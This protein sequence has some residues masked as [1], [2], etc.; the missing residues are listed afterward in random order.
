MEKI[1]K[2]DQ[3]IIFDERKF[4]KTILHDRLNQ[5]GYNIAFSCSS[6]GDL[7]SAL[8]GQYGALLINGEGVLEDSLGIIRNVHKLFPKL[9]IIGFSG[10]SGKIVVDT[11]SAAGASH[12]SSCMGLNDFLHALAK[13]SSFYKPFSQTLQDSFYSDQQIFKRL[14]KN[15]YNALI[16]YYMSKGKETNQ[17]PDFMNI[18]FST[19][20]TYRKRMM[21]DLDCGSACE[22]VAKAKDHHVI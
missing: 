12:L 5:L 9:K 10:G 20:K 13:A 17:M 22:L 6:S 19:I 15:P 11:F 7:F 18:K 16:L 4:F 1:E 21:D 3:L 8:S 14:L 2:G